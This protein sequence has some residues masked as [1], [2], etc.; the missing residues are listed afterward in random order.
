MTLWD[1]LRGRPEAVLRLPSG[2]M[3]RQDTA[4]RWERGEDKPRKLKRRQRLKLRRDDARQ[5]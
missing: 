3:I 2:Q 1:R 4:K 5:D